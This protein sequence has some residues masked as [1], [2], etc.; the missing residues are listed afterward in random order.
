MNARSA[1]PQTSAEAKIAAD[2]V[3]ARLSLPGG[4]AVARR[5][6]AIKLWMMHYVGCTI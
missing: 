2:Y 5:K 4:N 6:S 1:P 3:G